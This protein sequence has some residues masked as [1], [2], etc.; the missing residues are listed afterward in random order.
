MLH[1]AQE[2]ED[3]HSW[4]PIESVHD[5]LQEYIR[6][7]NKMMDLY[8]VLFPGDLPSSSEEMGHRTRFGGQ[9]RWIQPTDYPNC[10]VCGSPMPFIGEIDSV[11]LAQSE[12]AKGSFTF[13]DAGMFYIFH[14]C[15]LSKVIDSSC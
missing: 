8:S 5:A 14:C 3:D 12:K 9:P 10:D 1:A 7:S 6:I 11:G 15:G 4:I 13:N 2:A